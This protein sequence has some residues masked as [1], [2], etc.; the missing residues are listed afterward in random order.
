MCISPTNAAVAF[1]T[2][3]LWN[4]DA[5]EISWET[6]LTTEETA[7]RTYTIHGRESL[8]DVGGWVSPTDVEDALALCCLRRH[9]L[10]NGARS[11]E[12]R[13]AQR[14]GAFL[15][16]R[17]ALG[18]VLAARRPSRLPRAHAHAVE[19]RLRANFDKID[20]C[21]LN[22]SEEKGRHV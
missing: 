4:D 19:L 20:A 10:R 3:I 18:H 16:R 17:G 1:R 7:K 14:R 9:P 15:V 5:Q 6:K 2:V 8:T 13:E 21:F 12:V 11:G 22:F